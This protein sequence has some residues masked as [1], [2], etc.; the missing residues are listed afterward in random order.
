[1]QRQRRRDTGPELV[2]RSELWRRGYRFR[3]D[4]AI[5]GPRRRV[6][7]AFTKAKVA[8]FVDGCFWHSCPAHGSI[9]KSNTEWWVKKLAANAERDRRADYELTMAGWSVV[10]VWEHEPIGVAADRVEKLVRY[11]STDPDIALRSPKPVTPSV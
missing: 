7:I 8:V 6:D 9:P 1:M 11:R 10:R 4:F 3:V 5:L 2:L